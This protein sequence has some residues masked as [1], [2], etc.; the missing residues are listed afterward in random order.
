MYAGSKY[1]LENFSSLV[2]IL[3]SDNNFDKFSKL[4][5]DSERVKFLYNYAI[6]QPINFVDDKKD[7]AIAN[8]LK[9][10]ANCAFGH[11]DYKKA[12]TRYNEALIA[13]PVNTRK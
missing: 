7:S 8:E 6:G 11:S 13:C 5:T 2:Q 4:Q 1:L 9:T 10:R 3:R 12:L